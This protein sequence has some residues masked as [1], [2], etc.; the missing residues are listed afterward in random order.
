[1]VELVGGD[2]GGLGWD[3]CVATSGR[4]SR[5]WLSPVAKVRFLNALRFKRVSSR[6]GTIVCVLILLPDGGN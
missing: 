1:M 2:D 5:V 6:F 4:D 3:S